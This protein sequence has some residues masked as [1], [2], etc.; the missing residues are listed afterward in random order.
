VRRQ[1]R[2]LYSK[3]GVQINPGGTFSDIKK[4]YEDNFKNGT[5]SVVI[6]TDEAWPISSDVVLANGGP[7]VSRTHEPPKLSFFWSCV[8]VREGGQMKIRMLTVGMKPPPPKEA[9]ADK[10]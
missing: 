1:A 6:T 4:I 7:D 8:Y 5:E 10:K 2:T 9:S 3:D